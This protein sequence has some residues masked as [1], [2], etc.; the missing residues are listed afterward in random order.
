VN[1]VTTLAMA[2]VL[3]TAALASA[4]ARTQ[5]GV[6][7]SATGWMLLALVFAIL[8][9]FDATP[10]GPISGNGF[11][12][13]S[14]QCSVQP[15]HIIDAVAGGASFLAFLVGTAGGFVYAQTG[16]VAGRKTF[17]VALFLALGL[18]FVLF[19]ADGSLARQH[20]SD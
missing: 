7:V 17:R 4:R 8:V 16:A 15:V 6:L 13:A 14:G 2:A 5:T 1:I 19:A 10:C 11:L 20:P 3:V 18:M 12:T 9:V